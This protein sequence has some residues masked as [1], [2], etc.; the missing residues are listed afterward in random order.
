VPE[1][2][3]ELV[4][5][6]SIELAIAFEAAGYTCHPWRRTY[7]IKRSEAYQLSNCT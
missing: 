7:L 3:G 4:E 5:T 1:L 6:N 2:V